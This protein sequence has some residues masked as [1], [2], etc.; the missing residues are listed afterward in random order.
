MAEQTD[1]QVHF[2]DESE[3]LRKTLEQMR[4]EAEEEL[5]R[6]STRLA[7]REFAPDSSIATATE[8]L[9]LQQEMMMLQQT[10]EA[11][12]QALD[13][14]TEECRRLEDELEDHNIAFD[15]LK[16]EVDRKDKSLREAQAEAE[17]L[18][19]ELAEAKRAVAARPVPQPAPVIVNEKPRKTSVWLLVGAGLLF[20][21]LSLAAVTFLYLIWERIELPLPSIQPRAESPAPD[22]IVLDPSEPGATGPPGM[23]APPAAISANR[24]TRAPR[25]HQDR[26]RDGV[27]GPAM[28]VLDGGA[29]QMGYNSLSGEDFGPAHRVEPRPFMIGAHEV[30][31]LEYDRFARATGLE[32]P[33]DR[34]W[35]RGTR[36]VVG[37]T[38]NQATDYAAWLSRQTNQRYRLP[39]EAEW[40]FA[41]RAGTESP[42][43]WGSNPE[44]NRA[45]CLDCGSQWDNRSTAPVMSFPSNP[46]GLYDT[47]GNA[48]EWVADCYEASYQGAPTDGGARLD[49][50]CPSRVARGGAFNKPSALM[51]VHV[52]ARFAPETELNMLG[53]RIARDS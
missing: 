35:G 37:V 38:W 43:W 9:A 32:P 8:R 45:A 5:T 29:F 12:E 21:L 31:F 36:P 50:D 20:V 3:S 10:L 2:D 40:E 7:E 23:D 16:K 39:T 27:P 51:R 30:T 52:R 19:Q 1:S 26:L 34:G 28:V 13:H 24:L 48:M 17:R 11:K 47:A 25:I 42:F 14:I 6:L 4:K 22:A 44:R 41:A 33:D 46:F 18:R 15:S 49:G 53:F